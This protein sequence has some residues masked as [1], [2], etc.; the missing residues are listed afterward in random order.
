MADKASFLSVDEAITI[1]KD[2]LEE[3]YSKRGLKGVELSQAIRSELVTLTDRQL[4]ARALESFYGA[5]GGRS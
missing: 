4:K 3:K 5:S 2:Q 1:V